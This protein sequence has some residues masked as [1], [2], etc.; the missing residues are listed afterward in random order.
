MS[1]MKKNKLYKN[2]HLDCTAVVVGREG[3]E[4]GEERCGG[5]KSRDVSRIFPWPPYFGSGDAGSKGAQ[6]EEEEED[7]EKEET[8]ILVQRGILEFA[9]FIC[10]PHGRHHHLFMWREDIA[11]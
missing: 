5:R 3:M 7:V 2:Y 1:E 4:R 11:F 9:R 10:V 8:S 6:E